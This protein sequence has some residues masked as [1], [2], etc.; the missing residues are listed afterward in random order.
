MSKRGKGFHIPESVQKFAERAEGNDYP[1]RDFKKFKKKYDGFAESKKEL[2]NDYYDSIIEQ[3]SDPIYFC[4]RYGHINRD[5]VKRTK[6]LIYRRF[7]DEDLL[8]R[9]KKFVKD[10]GVKEIRNL[11]WFPIIGKEIMEYA[12][13]KNAEAL[14]QNPNA[15][16]YD[17]KTVAEV[18]EL[19][20]KKQLKKCEKEDID[21]AVAFDLLCI[22][23]SKDLFYNGNGEI[24]GEFFRIRQFYDALYTH[25]VNKEIPFNAIMETI[26]PEELHASFITFALLE[27]KEKFTKLNDSQKALYLKITSWCFDVMEK[28]LKK[29]EV[30]KIIGSYVS[31]RKKDD[32]DEKDGNRRYTLTTLPE[33]DYP[34]ILKQVKGIIEDDPSSE[35]YL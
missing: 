31:V 13:Q 1:K 5:D 17:L 7:T 26:V 35:K 33:K 23:P 21:K 6:G 25:A 9:L 2:K 4:V 24:R 28:K 18:C 34:R 12:A 29:D 8:K 27:R 3:M 11:K 10:E 30:K 19:I 32:K 16:T 15:D 20:L 22:I 14:E